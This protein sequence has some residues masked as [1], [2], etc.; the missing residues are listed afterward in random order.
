M[1]SL[2]LAF[3]IIFIAMLVRYFALA[4]GM[5]YISLKTKRPYLSS[6]AQKKFHLKRDIYWSVISTIIFAGSGVWLLHLWQTGQTKI[7]FQMNEYGYFYLVFSFFLL[8][9]LQDTYFYWT[10]RLLHTP[11]LFQRFHLAHHQSKAP[12]AWTSFAFH[13]IEAFLQ[14]LIVPILLQFIPVHFSIF[15]LFLVTMTFFGIFNHL[16]FEFLPLVLDRKFGIITATHHHVHHQKIQKN[17]GLFF[18]W[19]DLAMK[20]EDQIKE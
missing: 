12:T 20:T 16:G 1:L 4:G 8:L 19:W 2:F 17:Y 7:Y 10:H 6:Q 15:I 13:P 5:Y 11:I 14:A 9:L 18:R 3:V